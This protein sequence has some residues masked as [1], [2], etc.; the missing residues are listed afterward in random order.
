MDFTDSYAFDYD[1]KDSY[2]NFSDCVVS[3]F[4]CIVYLRSETLYFNYFVINRRFCSRERL[5]S[6]LVLIDFLGVRSSLKTLL[7]IV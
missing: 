6:D 5:L 4:V 1:M 3:N 2:L 7:I